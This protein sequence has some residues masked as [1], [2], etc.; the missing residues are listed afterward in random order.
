MF[1]KLKSR[2]A[3]FHVGHTS[4]QVRQL[5][6]RIVLARLRS[7]GG[8]RGSSMIEQRARLG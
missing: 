1:R 2:E 4:P 7:C 5:P 6:M 8:V 3:L